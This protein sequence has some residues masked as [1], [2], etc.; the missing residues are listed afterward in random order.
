LFDFDE[1]TSA[2]DAPTTQVSPRVPNNPI[3]T[4]GRQKIIIPTA[5]PGGKFT[6]LPDT[7]RMLYGEVMRLSPSAAD[8]YAGCP[9]AFFAKYG[10]RLDVMKVADYNPAE[11][12]T[13]IHYIME[14]VLRRYPDMSS[15]DERGAAAAA[16]EVLKEYA[17]KI[18]PDTGE[19]DARFIYQYDKLRQAAKLLINS[20]HTEAFATAFIPRAFEVNIGKDIPYLVIDEGA[21][22]GGIVDRVDIYDSP[23]GPYVRVIDYK[24]GD[25][26]LSLKNINNGLDTQMIVYLAAIAESRND[27]G[28]L[29]LPAAALYMP[30]AMP[31][32]C[33]K[34]G[35]RATEEEI[36]YQR[37][38]AYRKNGIF[39]R[40][41]DILRKMDEA[42]SGFFIR[43]WLDSKGEFRKDAELC[44]D[45]EQMEKLFGKVKDIYRDLRDDVRRG[46]IAASPLKRGS[47]YDACRWCDNK[48]LCRYEQGIYKNRSMKGGD[49]NA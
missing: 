9:F 27:S 35:R 44:L 47:V 32:P 40:D 17:E 7:A 13:F 34:L 10:L 37:A 5:L 2:G 3:E 49:D 23:D 19:L 39:L 28:S 14:E 11:I 22:V 8:T 48:P 24:T 45:Y 25:K 21:V 41:A 30:S 46:N 1:I 12:G 6:I 38:R 42:Q 29:L 36:Q 43:N 33:D 16:E 15:L 31:Q 26:S 18:L 20:V 4:D